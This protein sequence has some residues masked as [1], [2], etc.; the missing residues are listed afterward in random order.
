[1]AQ[2]EIIFMSNALESKSLKALIC[3]LVLVKKT[4]PTRICQYLL[5]N[6]TW[7]G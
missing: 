6:L 4:E 3:V 1:M 2:M 7:I 5:L